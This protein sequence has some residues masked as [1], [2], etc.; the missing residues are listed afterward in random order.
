MEDNSVNSGGYTGKLEGISVVYHIRCSF[1]RHRLTENRIF[2]EETVDN[3]RMVRCV[4]RPCELQVW[5]KAIILNKSGG[6]DE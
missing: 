5:Q 1:C 6:H 3:I 4:C 2:S